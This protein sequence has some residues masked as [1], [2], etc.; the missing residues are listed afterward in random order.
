MLPLELMSSW[1]AGDHGVVCRPALAEE[2]PEVLLLAG[3]LTSGSADDDAAA[4]TAAT[5]GGDGIAAERSSMMVVV[6]AAL[7]CLVPCKRPHAISCSGRWLL[8]S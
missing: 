1:A 7:Q 6:V 5:A 8:L 2:A 3:L 4:A